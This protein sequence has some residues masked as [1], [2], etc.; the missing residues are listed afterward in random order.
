MASSIFP[1]FLF[2]F[3]SL[4]CLEGAGRRSVGGREGKRG[5]DTQDRVLCGYVMGEDRADL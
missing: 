3:A 2:V 5:A 1:E 4:F